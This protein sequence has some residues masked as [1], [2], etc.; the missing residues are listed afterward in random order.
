M[1]ITI[2]RT[3][4]MLERIVR[5]FLE[6]A[7][8]SPTARF[9]AAHAIV[10]ATIT[11]LRG[12]AQNQSAGL[13]DITGGV[14]ACGSLRKELRNY[15]RDINRTGRVLDKDHPGIGGTFRLPRSM[16]AM[17]LLA[18][19]EI[20]E[21]AATELETEFVAAGLP[22]SFLTELANLI[23][24][25]RDAIAQKHDGR[26]Q[27]SGGT[28]ELKAQAARGIEA[29]RELDMFVRNHFRGDADAIGAWATA[30]RIERAA[31]KTETTTTPPVTPPSGGEGDG[32]GTTST[33]TA[34]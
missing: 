32:S 5:Y 13:S 21:A 17:Q 4:D 7:I 14:D 27:R 29:A 11:A 24:G 30:R 15:L 10:V 19:A 34:G 18:S 9:T 28:A 23:D 33:V 2:V 26:I 22:A 3:T 6:R 25:Y 1:N 31:R 20:I 8:T 16:T 12:A